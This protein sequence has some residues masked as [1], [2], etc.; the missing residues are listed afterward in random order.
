MPILERRRVGGGGVSYEKQP[1]P[2]TDILLETKY[3][4]IFD[5]V[6]VLARDELEK[7]N[8]ENNL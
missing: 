5:Y 2:R 6:S 7:E 1:I 4:K 8:K 3:N